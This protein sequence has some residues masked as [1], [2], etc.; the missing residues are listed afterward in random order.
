MEYTQEI[1]LDLN[2]RS[3]PPVIYGA[4]QGDNNTRIIKINLTQDDTEYQL[5]GSELIILRARKPDGTDIGNAGQINLEDNSIY[6]TL[7]EQTL[8][9]SGRVLADLLLYSNSNEYLSTAS[10]IIDVAPAPISVMRKVPSTDEM[11]VF[12]DLLAQVAGVPSQVN[13]AQAAKNAA[14]AAASSAQ[15]ARNSAWAAVNSIN[16]EGIQITSGSLLTPG[17]FPSSGV[18]EKTNKNTFVFHAPAVKPTATASLVYGDIS[19]SQASVEVSVESGTPTAGEDSNLLVNFDFDF[20]LPTPTVT[21]TTS[22]DSS[23]R[24]KAADAAAVASAIKSAVPSFFDSNNVLSRLNGGTGIAVSDPSDPSEVISR[25]GGQVSKKLCS[26]T[27]EPSH[28]SSSGSIFSCT[29]PVSGVTTDSNQL[30]QITEADINSKK[31]AG[32]AV[33]YPSTANSGNLIF[34]CKSVPEGPITLNIVI[35]D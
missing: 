28:W 17:T 27:I 34:T 22:I 12:A 2:T 25:L 1:T 8:A 24:G 21:L 10:F 23:G 20:K 31:Y 6:I 3:A 16:I 13:A 19:A 9:V 32:E 18:I 29:K 7:T 11:G 30:I 33:L 14:E 4:K 15:A 5:T 26:V 35:W